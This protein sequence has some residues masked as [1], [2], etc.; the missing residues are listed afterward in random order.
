VKIIERTECD[1][2]CVFVEFEAESNIQSRDHLVE[3]IAID[4]D[5]PALAD[6]V[7]IDQP[8][9]GTATEITEQ[10]N[11]ENGYRC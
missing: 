9:A 11:T 7:R 1:F 2:Q 10:R 5:K 4:F 6:A 3:V 8:P